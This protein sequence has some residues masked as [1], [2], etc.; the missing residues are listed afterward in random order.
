[1]PE[2]NGNN[3]RDYSKFDN[4]STEMLEDILRADSQLPDGENSDMDAILYIMEVIAKREK[5]HPTGKFTDVYAAWAS[6]GENYMPYTEDDKS[7]YNYEDMEETGIR[8]T[9]SQYPSHPLKKRRLM[10]VACIAAAV[11]VLLLAGTVTASALGFDLWGA[12]AKWTNDTFGFKSTTSDFQESLNSHDSN[13]EGKYS[14]LQEAL[15]NYD[16]TAK[17]AP[18]W[19]PGKYLLKDI[20][21]NQTPTQTTFYSNFVLDNNEIVVLVTALNEPSTRT[22]E[23]DD[24]NVTVYSSNGAM[25]YVMSNLGQTR[26]VWNTGNYECS[27]MG[28]FT[29]DE[30]KKMIDSIYERILT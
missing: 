17:L 28:N 19:F 9:R 4:M 27:I 22:Y 3:Q 5:E 20:E 11:T 29:L 2:S 18:T 12:V 8:H 14:S 13:G 30:A 10:R 6:F 26:I 21:I 25:Y 23:K 15:D 7:L 24:G 1:M 16:I